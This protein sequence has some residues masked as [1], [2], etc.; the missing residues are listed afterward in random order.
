MAV[1]LGRAWI[2]R[3]RHFRS[4]KRFVWRYIQT[5]GVSILPVRQA[6][7][8][9]RMTASS[10]KPT[11]IMLRFIAGA[12]SRELQISDIQDYIVKG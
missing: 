5:R 4:G 10:P 6:G 11:L 8:L 3:F 9:Q 2:C 12:A 7:A 1:R